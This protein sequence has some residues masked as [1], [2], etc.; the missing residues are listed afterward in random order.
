MGL[1]LSATTATGLIASKLLLLAGLTS[2]PVRYPLAVI[3]AYLVFLGMMRMWVGYVLID[4]P[5]RRRSISNWDLTSVD[6]PEF[7]GGSA[8]ESSFAFGGGDS[9]GGGASDAWGPADAIPS[10]GSSSGGGSSFPSLG[11]DIDLD[12]GIGILVVLAALVL[13]IFGAG[14]YLIY[15]APEILP[16]IAFNALLAGCLTGAVKRAETKGWVHSVF[17]STWIPL[18]IVLLMTIGLAVMIHRHCPGAPKLLDAL[19][20]DA[21]LR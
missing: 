5:A 1:I 7:G 10:G 21:G 16:D 15:V 19:G 17:R 6:V 4:K 8:S 14:G 20:C 9:G 3:L 13:A 18:T 11:L 12:D 2:I